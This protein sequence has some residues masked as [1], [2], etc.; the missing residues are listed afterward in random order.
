MNNWS[1]KTIDLV[2]SKNY[3]D[4]LQKIYSHEEGERNVAGNLVNSIT[5]SFQ[6]KDCEGLIG[7]LLDLEKFPY[8]DSYV[9]FL[10]KDRTAIAR[11]PDTVKRICDR[12]YSMGI[13]DVISGIKQSKEANTRRGNQFGNWLRTKYNSVGIDEFIKSKSGI[14]L[15][16]ASELEAKDFCNKHLHVGITKRPDIVAKSDKKFIIG[17]AKFLSSTGGNQGRAFDDG[18]K[19]ATNSDG[20]AYKIF[21]L[22]GVLWIERGSD[23]YKRIEYSTAL[24]FSV[25]L[26][27]NFLKEVGKG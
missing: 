19:L 3:L 15:L 6:K 9:G 7:K 16:E 12:L 13:D 22:D 5:E 20:S 4:Q 14:V 11:N 23:Q 24:I 25:L 21:I 27:D 2:N 8:K 10:R 17:E 18:I 26:L 1:Q